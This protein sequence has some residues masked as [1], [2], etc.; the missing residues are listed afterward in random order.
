[1]NNGAKPFG[2]ETSRG[3]SSLMIALMLITPSTKKKRNKCTLLRRKAVKA[4][5]LNKSET[6]NLNDFWNTY[7]PFLPPK[8]HLE[9]LNKRILR[10]LFNDVYSSYDEL[11]KKA[12][13]TSL[14]S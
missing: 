10:F 7:R 12:K 5:F 6:A 9:L 13:K 4:Y 14:Y 8:I 11:L 1:M 2:I 3:Q